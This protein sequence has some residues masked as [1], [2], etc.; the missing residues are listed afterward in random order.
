MRQELK[1]NNCWYSRIGKK[2]EI[3]WEG[4]EPSAAHPLFRETKDRAAGKGSRGLA[5]HKPHERVTGKNWDA[6]IP[7]CVSC[8][9]K[10]EITNRGG[11]L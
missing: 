6:G 10:R 7:I 5:P 1:Q 2:I 11:K 8:Q 4:R 9:K 3:Q